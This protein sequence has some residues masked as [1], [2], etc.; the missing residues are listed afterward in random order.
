MSLFQRTPPSFP[1]LQSHTLPH[2]T[3][4]AS[5]LLG[6]PSTPRPTLPGP[7]TP[8]LLPSPLDMTTQLSCVVILFPIFLLA[9]M[10]PP[11]PVLPS[12]IPTPRL[13]HFIAYALHRTCLHPS[14][15]FAAL[16][17][18]QLLKVCFPT[19]EGA[20]GHHLFISGKSSSVHSFPR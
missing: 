11:P 9:P 12:I 6:P 13:D 18:L 19:A 16:Y 14:V 15:T 3:L 1:A 4:P 8:V 7:P 17:L 20:S 10:S 5:C 2:L